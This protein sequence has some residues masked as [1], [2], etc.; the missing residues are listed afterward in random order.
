MGCTVP[1]GQ[2]YSQD[3]H[4]MQAESSTTGISGDSVSEAS[5]GTML[6]AAAGQFH[7]QEPH[8]ASPV[9]LRHIE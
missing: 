7:A 3:P 4:P 1:T 5:T 9:A 2:W 6:M 8:S